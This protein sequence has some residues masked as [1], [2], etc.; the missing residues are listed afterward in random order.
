MPA[1]AECPPR[2]ALL[3]YADFRQNTVLGFQRGM[4]DLGYST[5]VY[6]VYDA[7]GNQS[8]LD[9]LAAVI[10]ETSPDLAVAAGGIE[11]D[12]L[13][14]ATESTNIPVVFLAAASTVTRGLIE[15]MINPGANL[16]G[17]DSWDSELSE[18]RLEFITLVLPEARRVLVLHVPGIVSSAI[19]LEA[20]RSKASALGLELIVEEVETTEDIQ[21]VVL[22]I[23]RFEADALLLLPSAPVQQDCREIIFPACL[24][25]RIPIFGINCGDLFV[26]AC[27]SYGNSRYESGYQAALLA[28]RTLSGT[29]PS[30][31]PVEALRN[32]Q[33]RI[34]ISTVMLYE[35]LHIDS[36]AWDLA[37]T[38]LTVDVI[39]EGEGL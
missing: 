35:S 9:S 19:S 15:S 36:V 27:F 12:A 23:Q 4:N 18:K 25:N 13:K 24:Q 10:V 7:H 38:V 1:Q 29:D 16:T 33:F 22:N 14:L 8:A 31:I 11:A 34:N 2:I 39:S 3:I 17:I 37:D 28:H 6:E 26:G 32:P 20:V 30:T 21:K 5:A